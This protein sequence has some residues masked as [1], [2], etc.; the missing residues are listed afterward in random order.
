M[1][2]RWAFEGLLL[3]ETDDRPTWSP[4]VIP[5]LPAPNGAANAPAG[6]PSL[7]TTSVQ[8]ADLAVA[9]VATDPG[10]RGLESRATKQPKA[11]DM[12]ENFFPGETE[13]MGVRASV[14]ALMAI[15]ACFLVAIHV[16]LR[17]RDIH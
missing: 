1:P 10:D 9:K 17:S 6:A 7:Q 16:I 5:M 4:P 11:Q 8:P 12:A 14:I 13:R 15:L 3:L 2:T